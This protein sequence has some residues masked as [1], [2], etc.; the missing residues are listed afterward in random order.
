VLNIYPEAN[1]R[2][3]E[4]I[5][6]CGALLCEVN[7]Q[8]TLNALARRSLKSRLLP[9]RCLKYLCALTGAPDSD[10]VKCPDP[11]IVCVFKPKIY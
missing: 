5:L 1:I 9:D 8:A 2:L 3:S 7:P 10:F 11:L 4:K 6:Q